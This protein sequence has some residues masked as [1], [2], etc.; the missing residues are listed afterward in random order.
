MKFGFADVPACEGSHKTVEPTYAPTD[1]VDEEMLEP[2]VEVIRWLL[3]AQ[4]AL[5]LITFA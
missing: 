1:A 5:S 3:G 2:S 4:P